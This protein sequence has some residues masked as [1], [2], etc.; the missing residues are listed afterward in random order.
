[1]A[2]F[3]QDKYDRYFY[4]ILLIKKQKTHLNIYSYSENSECP[5]DELQLFIIVL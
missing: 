3:I 1:M 4:A 2:T 5:G